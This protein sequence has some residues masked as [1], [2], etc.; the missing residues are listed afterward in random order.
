MLL[1]Y[2]NFKRLTPSS[3]LQVTKTTTHLL[4]LMSFD[5]LS[6]SFLSARHD[7]LSLIDNLVQRVFDNPLGAGLL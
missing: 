3:L 2:L 1:K 7:Y 5:L 4:A 6:F